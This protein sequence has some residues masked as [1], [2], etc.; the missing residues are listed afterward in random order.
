V[1]INSQQTIGINL[2]DF[3]FY[4]QKNHHKQKEIMRQY[5]KIKKQTSSTRLEPSP[6]D[7]V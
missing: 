1:K 6:R 7:K 4:G 2:R 5:K 3:L